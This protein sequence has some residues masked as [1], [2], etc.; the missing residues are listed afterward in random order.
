V[1]LTTAVGSVGFVCLLSAFGLNLAGRLERTGGWYLILNLLGAGILA[2]YGLQKNT[3]IFV[4]LEAIWATATL[5]SLILGLRRR[6]SS[7]RVRQEQSTP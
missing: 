2:W 6:W 7:D 4:A 1:E 3:P 5:V